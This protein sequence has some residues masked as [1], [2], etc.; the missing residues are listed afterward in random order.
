MDDS[1]V[2]PR[3]AGFDKVGGAGYRWVA[4]EIVKRKYAKAS[5]SWGDGFIAHAARQEEGAGNP[6]TWLSVGTNRHI[7]FVTRQLASLYG[8]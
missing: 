4:S 2:V 8:P 7:T 1:W 6:T 5:Y 3:G